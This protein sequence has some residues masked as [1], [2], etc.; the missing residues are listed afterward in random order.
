MT[1]LQSVIA[2]SKGG[3]KE[4][5]ALQASHDL[6]RQLLVDLETKRAVSE[7]SIVL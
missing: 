2:L 6:I 7:I 3:S 4:R 1:F 5:A